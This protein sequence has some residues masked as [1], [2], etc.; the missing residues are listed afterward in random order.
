MAIGFI[1]GGAVSKVVAA[2]VT[3]VLNPILGLVIGATGELKDASLSIG[4]V[5]ILYGDLLSVFIDFLVIALLV[6]YGFKLLGL[7]KLSKKK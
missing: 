3:D 1:L 4:S 2:V 5:E 7:D 6:Y